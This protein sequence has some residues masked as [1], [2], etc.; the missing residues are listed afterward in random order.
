MEEIEKKC[1]CEYE[2]HRAKEGMNPH[3]RQSGMTIF[4]GS[5]IFAILWVAIMI[6]LAVINY[7]DP[8]A[9][10]SYLLG[11]TTTQIL[12]NYG[13]FISLWLV[14]LIFNGNLFGRIVQNAQACAILA[15][16]IVWANVELFLRI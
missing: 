11:K 13:V 1:S 6:A 12:G 16:S 8:W 14:D 9:Q 7:N 4:W 5:L 15:A 2:P 10:A 3:L